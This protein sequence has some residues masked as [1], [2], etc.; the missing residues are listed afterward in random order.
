M[1]RV[2]TVVEFFS[3][4]NFLIRTSA[5]V[6]KCHAAAGRALESIVIMKRLK[7]KKVHWKKTVADRFNYNEGISLVFLLSSINKLPV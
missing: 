1:P 3:H 4:Q 2:Q 5:N 7:K 6:T